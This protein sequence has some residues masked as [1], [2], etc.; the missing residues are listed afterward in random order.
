MNQNS[1]AHTCARL[2]VA[3]GECSWVVPQPKHVLKLQVRSKLNMKNNRKVHST[4]TEAFAAVATITRI[5]PKFGGVR[6]LLLAVPLALGLSVGSAA[7]GKPSIQSIEVSP[8]PLISGQNFTI[9]VTASPDVTQGTAIVDFQPG[10]QLLEVPLARAGQ[11]L[12]GSGV[13]PTDFESPERTRARVNVVLL[14][15]AG[16]VAKETVHVDVKVEL[17][18]AF[19]SAGVLTIFG[20]DLSNA[21]TVGRDAAGTILVNG[22]AVPVQGGVPTTNNTTRIQIIGLDGG[23]VLLVDDANGPMPRAILLGGEGSDSLTGSGNVDELDGGPGDDELSGRG[24]DDVVVG[25]PG[26]DNLNGGRGT[27]QFFGGEG[28]DQID[29]LPGEGSDLVEGEEGQDTL[30]FVGAVVDGDVEGVG[31]EAIGQRLHF[32]RSP[33]NITMDC[34][35]IERVEFLAVG[36]R[37]IVLVRNSLAGT[38]VKDI[39]VDLGP[40]DDVLDFVEIHGTFTNDVMTVTSS[41]NGVSVLNQGVTLT[42]VGSDSNDDLLFFLEDGDDFLDA[43]GLAVGFFNLLGV[44]RDGDDVLIGSAGDDRLV[45]EAGDDTLQGGPGLDELDGGTGN[46]IIIQD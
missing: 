30:L 44:G 25:G 8:N 5:R 39:V 35:G 34:D 38:Q 12:T 40:A 4:S 46:N 29:W 7:W 2:A 15:S 9:T 41:T 32:T 31:L 18:S 13:M 26:D 21:I 14:N 33:G 37:D 28:D 43:S 23:D 17:I 16:Q 24:G 3:Q 27:D 1:V 11:I 20:D 10:K 45:G 42:I 6:K 36:G 22:G 19:F